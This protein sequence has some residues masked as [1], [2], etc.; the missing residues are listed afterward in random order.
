MKSILELS[1]K[2]EEFS[3]NSEEEFDNRKIKGSTL[4]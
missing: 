2:M 1:A 3:W 4:F